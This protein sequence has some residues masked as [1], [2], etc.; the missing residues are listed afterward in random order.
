MWKSLRTSAALSSVLLLSVTACNQSAPPPPKPKGPSPSSVAWL[1]VANAFVEDYMRA[2]PSFAAQSGRHEFDGQLPDVSAHG[3]K[4]E[5]ARLHDEREQISA[6]DPKTLEPHDRFDRDYLLA[7]V[8]KDLFWIEKT[9]FPF[10]N[11]GWYLGKIDPELYLSRNYAPLE[12]RM[13]AYIQY[14]RGIPRVA[15][16]IKENLKSPLP[17][18]YVELGIAQF[19]GLADFYSKNVA[20]VFASVSNADLQKQLA[21]ANANAA[22]AMNDLKDYLAAERKNAT[23][24]Y[25]FGP[26]LF[27]QMVKQTEQVD[28]PIDQIEAAGRA[29]L[30]RNTAALKAECNT[31]APKAPLAQCVAKMAANKPKGGPVEE[32]RNQLKM[33]KEFIVQNNVVSIPSNDEALVAEAPPYNRSN[34]AF[35]NTAGP[36]DKGVVS[37]YNIAPPDP[38]W[39]KAEQASYIPGVAQ[40]LFTSVHEVWPG[41]FLQFLHSNA[42]P[43]K[44]EALWVGY[45]YAEGW[46]HYCEEMMVEMGLS[47]GDAE[48]H[49]GQLNEALL[50]D[51]R[52]MSAIGLHTH[53]MTVAQSEKMFREQAFQDPGNARQQA[54][55]GTYDPAYLNYTLG[56][57]MIRKLRADWLSKSAAGAGAPAPGSPSPDD[58]SRWHEFHDKFLSYGGPPIPLLRKEL[59]G[60]G[61]SLL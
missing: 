43:D 56:K 30:E 1:K 25:A 42:N 24:K 29:D 40:L 53:G 35:I 58:Q 18:T 28:L 39:S 15:K 5:I 16:A 4:R 22:A 9:Q 57:L 60:E 3:I 54:A 12:V 33:L 47:K 52:L 55:R 14:A 45:A 11:P 59:V 2:Q 23:D 46:A 20:P 13:K 6:V 41:H 38:K 8:D 44:L 36:Y 34:A 27:A 51:V 10:T 37:V 19:G 7:V 49:I 48:K 21:D 32:A 26:D 61:G 31:Y 17:K 50:R